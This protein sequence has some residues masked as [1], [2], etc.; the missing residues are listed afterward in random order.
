MVTYLIDESYVKHGLITP[1]GRLTPLGIEYG[2]ELI[3]DIWKVSHNSL[4]A[5]SMDWYTKVE[6][7]PPDVLTP[8]GKL[9]PC[10]IN[11]LLGYME[12]HIINKYTYL[13]ITQGKKQKCMA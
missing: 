13:E 4:R 1:D 8:N 11:W 2:I 10:G 3:D 6:D 9:T 5:I 7:V 12:R